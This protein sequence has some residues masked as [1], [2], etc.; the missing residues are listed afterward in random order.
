MI[1]SAHVSVGTAPVSLAEGGSN[2]V[3]VNAYNATGPVAFL[4]GGTAVASS[5]GRQL[6]SAEAVSLY[7]EQGESLYAVTAS[8]TATMQ[9]LRG[10]VSQ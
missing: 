1:E 10:G 6:G 8:G 4:G 9:V 7:V 5:N 2:G 3:R